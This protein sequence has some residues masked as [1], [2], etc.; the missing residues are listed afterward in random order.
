MLGCLAVP[1]AILFILSAVISFFTNWNRNEARCRAMMSGFIIGL[2]AYYT[3]YNHFPPESVSPLLS[4]TRVKIMVTMH[5]DQK[6]VEAPEG[7]PR[8]INYYDP[9]AAKEKKTGL[10]DGENKEP[11]LA[12]PW[13]TP[14][15]FM[16][17]PDEKEDVTNPV[18]RDNMQNPKIKASVI[19]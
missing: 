10:Y 16:V 5:P 3:E 19:V 15:Y 9:P 7:N 6:G 12:D 17:S 18:P 1:V 13:G 14:L 4:Q 8:K 11:I 2:K